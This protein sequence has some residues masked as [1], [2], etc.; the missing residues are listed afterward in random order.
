M[1]TNKRGLATQERREESCKDEDWRNVFLYLVAMISSTA[2]I[3]E[4]VRRRERRGFTSSLGCFF[5]RK[6]NRETC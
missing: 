2:E 3:C 5:Q 6:A 4:E 1:S